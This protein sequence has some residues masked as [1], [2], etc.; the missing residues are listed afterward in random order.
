MLHSA[1]SIFI[2]EYLCEYE[3]IFETA[4]AHESG[5]TNQNWWTKP[6]VLNLML[7]SL[8]LVILNDLKKLAATWSKYAQLSP[9]DTVF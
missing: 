1:E 6:R 2:I 8:Y 9:H 3:F 7:L 4:L 5:G